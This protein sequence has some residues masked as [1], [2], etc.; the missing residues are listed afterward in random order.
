MSLASLHRVWQFPVEM[1]E[2]SWKI[3]TS[4]IKTSTIKTIKI[5]NMGGA[6][7]GAT[8]HGQIRCHLH[9][10]TKHSRLFIEWKQGSKYYFLALSKVIS[11]SNPSFVLKSPPRWWQTDGRTLQRADRRTASDWA[12][13]Q[14]DWAHH[15]L[16]EWE[17]SSFRS[18]ICSNS[19]GN[20]QARLS[21]LNTVS[22]TSL[23]LS[24]RLEG[25]GDVSKSL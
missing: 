23:E 21:G 10:L 2:R 5:K 13:R 18:G 17:I 15:D 25:K 19:S 4:K 8:D 6:G 16:R 3:Q 22:P 9:Y 11:H 12:R 24:E 20:P 14:A 7:G 1:L